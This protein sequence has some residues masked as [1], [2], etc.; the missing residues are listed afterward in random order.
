[1]LDITHAQLT[2]MIWMDA[3]LVGAGRLN[4]SDIMAAFGISVSQVAADIQ[5]YAAIN[6]GRLQYNRRAR[7]YHARHA[8]RPAFA[9]DARMA[10]THA[11][12]IVM[13]RKSQ[14]GAAHA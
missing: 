7:A 5:R 2:R 4:R 3:R 6:P 1:M 12:Q 9:P 14:M 11:V 13:D 8:S 10:I